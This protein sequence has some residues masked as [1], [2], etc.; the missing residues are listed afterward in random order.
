MPKLKRKKIKKEMKL[1]I[2][3]LIMGIVVISGAISYK[4]Y[5]EHKKSSTETSSDTTKTDMD[6]GKTIL[7]SEEKK[8]LEDLQ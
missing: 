2:C 5:A 8:T 6:V 7:S 4:I 3:T 1:L